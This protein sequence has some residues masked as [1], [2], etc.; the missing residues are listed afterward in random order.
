MLFLSWRMVSF[1]RSSM[2]SF[3]EILKSTE[4]KFAYIFC[5]MRILIDLFGAALV[6]VGFVSF[7][8]MADSTYTYAIF[9]IAFLFCIFI[10]GVDIHYVIFRDLRHIRSTD[11]NKKEDALKKNKIEY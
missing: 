2:K 3:D 1:G 4:R 11:P 10:V 9:I 8:K 7:I 5:I 6:V